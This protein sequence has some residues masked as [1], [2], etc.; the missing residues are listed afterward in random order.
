M[1]IA[2]EA[3]PILIVVAVVFNKSNDVLPVVKLVVTA[4]EVRVLFVKVWIPVNVA[5]VESIVIVTV[6]E[7]IYEVPERPV[8]IVKAFGFDAVI[9]AEPPKLIDDPLIVIELFVN[10]VLAIEPANMVLVTDPVSPVVIA[11]PVTA[12]NVKVFVPAVAVAKTVIVP[13]VDPVN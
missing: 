6:L 2:V 12:G 5:T 8:P 10:F 13:E 4:G 1:D 11:V 7:P 3:P 9:V